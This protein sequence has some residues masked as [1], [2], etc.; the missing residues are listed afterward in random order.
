AVQNDPAAVD[1]DALQEWQRLAHRAAGFP[2]AFD[3]GFRQGCAV[4][5]RA[6]Q[7]IPRRHLNQ[8]FLREELLDKSSKRFIE[9]FFPTAGVGEEQAAIFQ[10]EAERPQLVVV[11]LELAAAVHVQELEIHHSPAID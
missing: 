5:I 6:K 4:Q 3:V 9:H 8:L 1:F 2:A 11:K 7:D 10:V